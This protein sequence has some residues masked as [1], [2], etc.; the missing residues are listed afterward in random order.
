MIPIKLCYIGGGSKAWARVFMNDLALTAGLTGEIALYDIDPVRLE[1]S[2]SMLE[3]INRNN[4]SKAGIGI[5]IYAGDEKVAEFKTAASEGFT[6]E[7]FDLSSKVTGKSDIRFV[8]DGSE[9]EIRSWK[10]N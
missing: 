8:F 3:A 2:A 10:F 9:G 6:E 4:G 1:E 7:T 5:C